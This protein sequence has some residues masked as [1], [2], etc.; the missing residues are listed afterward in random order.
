MLS[1]SQRQYS[2][3]SD[4]LELE[5]GVGDFSGVE[6]CSTRNPITGSFL[7]SVSRFLVSIVR[8]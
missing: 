6:L 3:E 4:K 2:P 1:K 7:T 8:E 5:C